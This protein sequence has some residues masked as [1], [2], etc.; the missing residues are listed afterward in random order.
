MPT[1][2]APRAATANGKTSNGK[3]GGARKPAQQSAPVSEPEREIIYPSAEERAQG[4]MYVCE[5]CYGD[6]AITVEQSKSLLGWREVGGREGSMFRDRYGKYIVCD[7]N[8]TNREIAWTKVEELVQVHLTRRPDGTPAWQFNGEDILVGCYGAI[9]NGQK[10]LISHVL[11]EQDRL[12]DVESKG[13]GPHEG[14]L[15]AMWPDPIRMEKGV[16]FGISEDDWVVN[17]VDT[18]QPRTLNDVMYRSHYLRDLKPDLRSVASRVAGYAIRMA[19]SRSGAGDLAFTPFRTHDAMLLF[20]ERHP[21]ILDAVRWVVTENAAKEEVH[22]GRLDDAGKPIIIKRGRVERIIEPSRA[23]ALLY[24]MGMSDTDPERYRQGDPPGEEDADDS[25]WDKAEDFWVGLCSGADDIEPVRVA[26]ANLRNKAAEMGYEPTGDEKVSVL[27]KAWT[28]FKAG[29]KLEAKNL[30]PNYRFYKDP[31]TGQREREY[32]KDWDFGGIDLLAIL[33]KEKREE[34]ERKGEEVEGPDDEDGAP[35]GKNRTPP[36]QNPQS[37]QRRR[38]ADNTGDD[39]T[40]DDTDAGDDVSD[41]DV[42][43]RDPTPA[44]LAALRRQNRALDN[45]TPEAERLRRERVE[46]EGEKRREADKTRKARARAGKK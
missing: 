18:A 27:C 46:A 31:E 34:A 44:E 8:T 7:N 12:I 33:E 19:W 1:R 2:E 40:S 21:R 22:S 6:A 45:E 10:S 4:M 9:I 30:K 29:E 24:M 35:G 20:L 28:A 37:D 15:A 17:T 39:D 14:R 23:A 5:M 25:A 36:G 26:L 38:S 42:V 41:G 13:N 16:K 3:R 11:A 32:I 43:E